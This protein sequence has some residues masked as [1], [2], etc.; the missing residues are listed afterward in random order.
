MKLTASEVYRYTRHLPLI[1]QKGQERLLKARILCVGAGGLGAPVLQ[2]LVASGIGSLGIIDGDRV[3]LSN[4]QRQ[5]IFNP[6]DIGKNKAERA[7]CYLKKFNPTLQTFVYETFL[8]EDNIEQVVDNYTIIID[9]TDNYRTRYLLNDIC[10]KYKKSLVFASIHQFLGQC[11]VFNYQEGPCYRCLY[12]IPPSEEILIPNCSLNGVL[13][14]L[15]GILGC[16][17]ATEVIKIVLEKGHVLSGR[18]LTVDIL[19]MK[20]NEFQILKN[21]NCPCCCLGKS[22]IELFSKR[23]FPME[24]NE[25]DPETLAQWINNQ[26]ED[27]FLLLDVREPYEREICHIGGRLIPL[28]ELE[29]HLVDF[30]KDRYIVCYCKSG[31]RGRRAVRILME[32]GFTRAMNLRKGITGWRDVID[33]S[34]I[35]Y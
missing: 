1:G 17:Q 2:Y 22:A 32:N 21:P 33:P 13:G 26:K 31:Q 29:I 35:R 7:N 3:E 27:D 19:S 9:C 10:V 24:I 34:L 16:I 6:N 20:F 8:S 14:V 25:I 15:P 4:L 30:P 11:S 5:V 28:H 23:N 18:L 12:E